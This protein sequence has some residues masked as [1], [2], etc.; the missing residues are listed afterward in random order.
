[1]K[2]GNVLR[3]FFFG[4]EKA[5]VF[6]N[7]TKRQ[8]G[9]DKVG[10]GILLFYVRCN[11]YQLMMTKSKLCQNLITDHKTPCNTPVHNRGLLRLDG[12]NRRN[13]GGLLTEKSA[14]V[15]FCVVFTGKADN[16]RR[17]QGRQQAD[18]LIHG[19]GH[20]NT[21]RPRKAADGDRRH[22]RKLR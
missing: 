22:F 20:G 6:E 12:G 8:A 9:T 4:L 19:F 16:T 14:R 10:L 1:M 7:G 11:Q 13:R 2:M 3:R 21:Q 18:Y 15:A 5:A 17:E